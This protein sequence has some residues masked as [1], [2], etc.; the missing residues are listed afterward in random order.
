MTIPMTEPTVSHHP[1]QQRFSVILDGQEAC[2]QYRQVGQALDFYRTYVPE[3]FRGRGIAERLCKAAFEFA[4]QQ[5]LM[6]IPSCS[7]IAGAYLRRHT[8]YEP[9]VKR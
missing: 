9:L 3:S 1:E 2:L 4:K 7:Y 8:E 6:V 5:G